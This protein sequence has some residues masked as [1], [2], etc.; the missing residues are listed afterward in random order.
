MTLTRLFGGPPLAVLLKL[1][2]LSVI[3]GVVLS[4][5]GL[6]PYD[7][8]DSFIDLIV[9]IYEMGFDAI[10]LAL[11]YFLLGAV[12]VFPVWL[13]FRLLKRFQTRE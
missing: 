11:R 3:V 6:S 10:E 9:R 5:L 4:A 1:V 13:I 8:V 12:I 7:I 2:V